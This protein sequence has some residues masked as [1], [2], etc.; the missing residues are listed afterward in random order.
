MRKRSLLAALALVVGSCSIPTDENA[1][2]IPQSD[3]APS[4]Q[5]N[6]TTTTSTTIPE[7]RTREFTYYLLADRADTPQ[8]EVRPVVASIPEGTLFEAIDIMDVEGFRERI[9]ADPG[10][11]NTVFQYDV[12]GLEIDDGVATVFLRTIDETPDTALRDVAA[13]LV[14]TVT[15]EEGVEALLINLDDAAIEL[16]TSNDDNLTGGP[17]TIDDYQAYDPD[18]TTTVPPDDN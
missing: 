3:L 4:L 14:W 12:V 1:Q 8:R 13:Q 16:P 11:L 2:V 10:L 15:G 5:Q 18:Q 17:V 6:P 7:I 9:G